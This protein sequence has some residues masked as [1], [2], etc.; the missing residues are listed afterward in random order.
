MT[1]DVESQRALE[2]NDGRRASLAQ[3]RSEVPLMQKES[4]GKKKED[5][6][7]VGGKI[8]GGFLRGNLE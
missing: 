8:E 4:N 1:A 5:R 6:K 2:G 3:G 7:I